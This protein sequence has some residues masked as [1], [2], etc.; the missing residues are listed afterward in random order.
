MDSKIEYAIK[1][2]NMAYS[3]AIIGLSGGADSAL[4]LHYFAEKSDEL[5]C[6]HVNHMIRGAEADR[7]EEFCKRICEKYG[8]P[9]VVH[10]IDIPRLAKEQGK[11]VEETARNERYRVFYEELDKRGYD[12]ILVAH[13]ADD[14]AESIIFNLAR[15]TGL[16]GLSGIKPVNG[17]VMRPLIYLSK[18]EIFSLCVENNIEYVTDSTNEDTEYTRNYIRHTVIPAVRELNPEL[19]S[20]VSRMTDTLRADE[21]FILSQAKEFM[22][23]YSDGCVDTAA[24]CSLHTSVRTRVLKL[25]SKKS[26]DF[27]SIKACE[28]LLFKSECG[29]YINLSEN[30][31]FKKEHS[32]VHFIDSGLLSTVEFSYPLKD[33]LI[34]TE[35]NAAVAFDRERENS[36]LLYTVRLLTDGING[37]LTVRSRLDGDRITANKMTK[38]VKR[39]LCDAH[40]PS[41]LRDKVPVICDSDGILAVGDICV[42]DRVKPKKGNNTT[43]I[44]FYK[45][46]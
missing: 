38:R 43:V 42:C 14:N 11:G 5:V 39:I 46:M 24:L 22:I 33:G 6:V 36:E 16:N 3:K 4:L 34:I 18:A 25:M 17:R 7:D 41:H 2:H 30:I 28:D 26:L 21:D 29:S 37:Q 10:R 44:N 9:L 12:A 8:V 1:T 35:L 40:I 20:A 19:Y 13:N 32:Y 23:S 31:A 15:G 27:K 45:S